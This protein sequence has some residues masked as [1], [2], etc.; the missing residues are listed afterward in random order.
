MKFMVPL[1]LSPATLYPAVLLLLRPLRAV[2]MPGINKIPGN[3]LITSKGNK[4]TD[5]TR[6][7]DG[8]T[9]TVTFAG[10]DRPNDRL[11][12]MWETLLLE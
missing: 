5:P 4:S 11:I 6:S 3:P 9:M 12:W 1:S 2:G 10:D 7:V 8:Q